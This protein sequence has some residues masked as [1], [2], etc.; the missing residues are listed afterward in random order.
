MMKGIVRKGDGTTHG[1]TVLEGIPNFLVHGVPVAGV[2]H[3]VFCPKCK[4]A[5]PIIEGDSGFTAHGY[6]VALH[7]MRTA[8]GALLI[9]ST[10]GF[11]NVE[12][13]RGIGSAYVGA[14]S[15]R[16]DT[17]TGTDSTVGFDDRYVLLDSKTAQPLASTEYAIRRA[18]GN[19]EFGVTDVEGR[20]HLLAA[21]AQAEDV[22]IF[23]EG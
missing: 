7:G 8:C 6:S 19:A 13:P 23:V 15:P 5:F 11:A 4:G 14:G 16:C 9:S 17:D 21:D 2:G 22:T 18:S 10:S 12:H 20:T 1:G 3:M